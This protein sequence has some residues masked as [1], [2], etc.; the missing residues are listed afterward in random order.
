MLIWAIAVAAGLVAAWLAYGWHS[1]GLARVAALARFVAVAGS[2]ALLLDATAGR[3][4]VSPRLVA[5][6]VSSSWRRSRDSAAFIAAWKAAE[7]EAVDSV[8]VFGDS[9][10]GA[11]SPPVAS[12][13]ASR[14]RPLVE[15]ALA[16]GRPLAVYTDGEVDDAAALGALPAGSRIVVGPPAAGLDAAVTDV[17]APSAVVTGDSLE[18]LVTVAAGSTG[19]PPGRLQV[20]LADRLAPSIVLDSLGAY[21][22]RTLRTRFVVPAIA[23]PALLRAVVSVPGDVEPRNDTVAVAIDL[24]PGA[25][26][27]FV[28]TSPDLDVRE[29]ATVLRGTVALPTRG[30]FRVAP[31]VWREEGTLAS[32]TEDQVRRW[33]KDAPV[34]VIHGDTA[35]FGEPRA[36]SRGSLMLM[37]PP[38]QATG[39]WYATGAPPSPVAAALTGSSWD[40]LPPLEVSPNV[41]AGEWDVLETRRA[42]R[43]ERRVAIVGWEQPRRVVVVGASGFW[44]WRFRGGVGVG[45]HTALW[46]SLLDWMAA[47]HSDLRAAVPVTGLVRSGDAIRWRRGSGAD[48]LVQAVLVRRGMDSGDTLMLRFAP[49]MAT[50][51]TPP[52]AEGVY[53]VKVHGGNALLVVNATAEM[54]PRRPNLQSGTIGGGAVSGDAPRLRNLGW[55]F[56]LLIAALCAEWILRRRLGLR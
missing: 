28:S 2:V 43:L 16:T 45:I 5:L 3:Q 44:R 19:S 54:L 4:R 26:A 41:P 31:G 13:R 7:D 11:S 23:G 51:D 27:V 33:A 53:E 14:V 25:G 55:V 18:V 48:T 24:A 47:E 36:S 17:R 20:T 22:E 38:T 6:D 39:E 56:A 1:A 52:L 35:V 37:A 42:R 29:L 32:V 50:T 15:H 21:A 10:R 46:G 34:L 30:F 9:V 8:L 49:G 12:D 40:S